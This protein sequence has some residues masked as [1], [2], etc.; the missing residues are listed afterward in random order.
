M[1]DW[2]PMQ[3]G[4]ASHVLLLLALAQ[5][6]GGA[7]SLAMTANVI[8]TVT[9]KAQACLSPACPSSST[10]VHSLASCHA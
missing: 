6:D 2:G 4:R 1:A 7:P 8:H 3:V 9:P 5:A 10:D